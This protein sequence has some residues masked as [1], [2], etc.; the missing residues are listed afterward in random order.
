M[1]MGPG[2]AAKT[3]WLPPGTWVD[4][5]SGVVTTVAATDVAHMLTKEYAINE[6]GSSSSDAAI[7]HCKELCRISHVWS[8][9]CRVVTVNSS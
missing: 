9:T 6:V 1:G 7:P 5:N 8:L 3:T 2:M 4:V